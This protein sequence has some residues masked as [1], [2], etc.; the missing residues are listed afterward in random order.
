MRFLE[1][2]TFFLYVIE[3]WLNLVKLIWFMMILFVFGLVI[4]IEIVIG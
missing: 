4:S 1:V 3:V 2:S